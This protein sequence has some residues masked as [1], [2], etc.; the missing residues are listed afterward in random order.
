MTE[1]KKFILPILACVFFNLW[2]NSMTA[3]LFLW[4]TFGTLEQIYRSK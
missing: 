2:L 1:Y 3:G 4:F